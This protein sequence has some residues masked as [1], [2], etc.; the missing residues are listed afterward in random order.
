MS[1]WVLEMCVQQR[2]SRAALVGS[3]VLGLTAVGMGAYAAHGLAV[4][5]SAESLAAVHTAVQYQMWHALAL[6][7]ISRLPADRWR[8]AVVLLWIGGTLCFAGSLYALVFT[9]LRPGLLTPFGGLLLM[10]G[11]L[12]L[13]L[14]A[15]FRASADSVKKEPLI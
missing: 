13:M 1:V 5:L 10:C 12:V 6:L 8:Q 14:S 2:L 11:W 15:F 9:S 7:A 4:V 3:G